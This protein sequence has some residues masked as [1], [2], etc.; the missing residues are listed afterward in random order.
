MQ[1]P[2]HWTRQLVVRSLTSSLLALGIVATGSTLNAPPLPGSAQPAH[3]KDA[4]E[5]V[6]ERAGMA[7]VTIRTTN[8]YGSG[9]IVRAD[10]LILTNAH[11]VKN[12]RQVTV[13][14]K[15]GRSF[16]ADVLGYSK[17]CLDLAVVKIQDTVPLPTLPIAAVES[18]KQG[19]QVFAIGS[20]GMLDNSMT[21]GI[22]SRVIP[23][24]GL[25]QTDASIRP[26]NSGGPLLNRNGAM[27]GVN[28]FIRPMPNAAFAISTDRVQ[29]FLQQFDQGEVSPHATDS[30]PSHGTQAVSLQAGSRISGILPSS[31]GSCNN[32]REYRFV[33]KAGQQVFVHLASQTFTPALTLYAPDGRTK[34]DSNREGARFAAIV[35]Q[36]PVNGT[37]RIIATARDAGQSGNYALSVVPL[38]LWRQDSL[39]PGDPVRN[40]SLYREYTFQGQANQPI[41]VLAN[42][43]QFDTQVCVTTTDGK[44]LGCNDNEN[45]RTTNSALKLKLPQSGSYKIT[46]TSPKREQGAFVLSVL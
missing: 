2:T 9:S 12:A 40:G 14:L 27:I 4:G 26:G 37:Y 46:V 15:D 39:Q 32:A 21:S 25:I 17:Q 18:V 8:G 24:D 33:G 44:L 29:A 16:Q 42:S 36:L 7:V 34:E 20:P 6:A 5:Q 30:R 23:T 28:T 41:T 35:T 11:V 13:L 10:G 3:A 43:S 45:N 1:H 31:G 38:V 19:Q 22:V